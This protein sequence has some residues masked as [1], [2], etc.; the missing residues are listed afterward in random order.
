MIDILVMTNI[1]G[2]VL[3]LSSTTVGVIKKIYTLDNLVS[4]GNGFALQIASH[5]LFSLENLF[6]SSCKAIMYLLD[7]YIV[8]IICIYAKVTYLK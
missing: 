6:I 7:I 4:P 5:I 8:F 3:E 1:S 2:I